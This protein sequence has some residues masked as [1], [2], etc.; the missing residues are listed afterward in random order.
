M[1]RKGFD[2]FL[3]NRDVF[4]ESDYQVKC[5]NLLKGIL[6]ELK[7]PDN[8]NTRK[9]INHWLQAATLEEKV[10]S[11][12]VEYYAIESKMFFVTIPKEDKSVT[13]I[14]VNKAKREA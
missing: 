8:T 11:T 2:L 13:I 4:V 5:D 1:I 3:G 14:K 6:R 10:T 12:G 9:Y 7:M